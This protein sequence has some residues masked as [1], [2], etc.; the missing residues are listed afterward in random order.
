MEIKNGRWVDS[1]GDRLN[2][3]NYAQFKLLSNNVTSLYGKEITYNRISLLS[4]LKSLTRSEEA[5]VEDLLGNT[6]ILSKL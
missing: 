6:A 1:N 4:R 2:N 3:F 5:I